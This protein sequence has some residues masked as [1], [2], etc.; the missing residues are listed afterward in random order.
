[1]TP[2]M[3][4]PKARLKPQIDPDEGHDA[5]A[6][7]ALHHDGDHVLVAHEAAIEERQARR[8]DGHQRGTEENEC[9]VAGVDMAHGGRA[10]LAGSGSL[11][12]GPGSRLPARVT[13]PDRGEGRTF[14]A[15][16]VARACPNQ[17]KHLPGHRRS[18]GQVVMTRCVLR[19]G[20]KTT[21]RG[22]SLASFRPAPGSGSFAR[23]I[24]LFGRHRC[25]R[26]TR[27]H[28]PCWRGL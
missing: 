1:M 22:E 8:H 11:R 3:S 25:R 19:F 27:P 26:P 24:C 16:A 28:R 7:E 6:D 17:L 14:A 2:W 5:E 4:G 21:G 20:C 15:P 9:G 10:L 12:Q 13:G 18:T 23:R